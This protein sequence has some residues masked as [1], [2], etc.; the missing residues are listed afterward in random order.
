MQISAQSVKRYHQKLWAKINLVL[1]S[2]QCAPV[3][4]LKNLVTLWILCLCMVGK[5]WAEKPS[6]PTADSQVVENAVSGECP[7]I[8]FVSRHFTL[9]RGVYFVAP[10]FTFI[11]LLSSADAHCR[12]W[13]S[14]LLYVPHR[15]D[16]F[17]SP[18]ATICG[19]AENSPAGIL[20]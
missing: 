20:H 2:F 5:G 17:F 9:C 14:I 8:C 3:M 13:V 16:F 6:S 19:H 15:S 1:S 7:V 10:C 12:P 4:E 18:S 11:H